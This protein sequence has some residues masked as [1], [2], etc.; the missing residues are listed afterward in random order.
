MLM[1]E[2]TLQISSFRIIVVLWVPVVGM[3]SVPRLLPRVRTVTDSIF[4]VGRRILLRSSL[5]ITTTLE[6]LL[7]KTSSSVVRR[8]TV[9][10]RLKVSFLPCRLVG[11]TP[12]ATLFPGKRKLPRRSVVPT[13]L[14]FLPIVPLFR[15]AKRHTTLPATSILTATAAICRLPI[16]V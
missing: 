3:T 2:L 9:R 7:V 10:G 1:R 8:L 15:F 4:P 11:V 16:V 14:C 6:R 5:L 13:W 12:I